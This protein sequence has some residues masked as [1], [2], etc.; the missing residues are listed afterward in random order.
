[1]GRGMGRIPTI[2]QIEAITLRAEGK[3]YSEIGRLMGVTE[4][5]AAQMARDGALKLIK[6]GAKPSMER[7]AEKAR[8][9]FPHVAAR[10]PQKET[11]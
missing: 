10:Y 2:R 5:T 1:M 9:C 8:A 7:L 11:T 6:Y 4:A 3:K